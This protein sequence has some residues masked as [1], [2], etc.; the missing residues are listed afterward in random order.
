MRILI[1]E[2]EWL[3]ADS[4]C[5]LL[6]AKAAFKIA[7]SER[8][9]LAFVDVRLRDRCTGPEIGT[10]LAKRG[11]AVIFVTAEPHLAPHDHAHVVGVLPKPVADHE[12]LVALARHRQQ[13]GAK[14]NDRAD[15]AK[16]PSYN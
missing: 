10:S 2:D 1:V 14:R 8:P 9:D 15:V 11:I 12:Y 7:D 6:E 4:L 5:S 13:R 16:G 3:L